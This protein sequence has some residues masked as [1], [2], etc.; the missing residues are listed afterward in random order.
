MFPFFQDDNALVVGEAFKILEGK[1]MMIQAIIAYM[2]TK[3]WK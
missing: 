1:I 2:P 3:F